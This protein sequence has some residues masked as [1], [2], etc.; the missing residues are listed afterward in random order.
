M[1]VF[2]AFDGVFFCVLVISIQVAN[3]GDGF[4]GTFDG[5]PRC[6]QTRSPDGIS[7]G[8]NRWLWVKNTGYPKTPVW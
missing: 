8:L 4:S 5:I 7:L 3:L 1:V 6:S 2:I